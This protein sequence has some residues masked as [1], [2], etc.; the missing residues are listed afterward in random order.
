MASDHCSCNNI[1]QLFNSLI[2]I[3][4]SSTSFLF[5]LLSLIISFN[6]FC[7]ME[8]LF[9]LFEYFITIK[10]NII[11]LGYVFPIFIKREIRVDKT[12]DSFKLNLHN[13]W[14][15]TIKKES[16][17]I[18][19]KLELIK[20]IKSLLAEEGSKNISINL[21]KSW[22]IFFFFCRPIIIEYLKPSTAFTA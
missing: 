3:S 10:L 12:F 21:N 9:L 7:A 14:G 8:T 1:A 2:N 19:L 15:R 6:I 13:N 17:S 22:K 4:L 18:S 16:T 5:V 11:D 20:L